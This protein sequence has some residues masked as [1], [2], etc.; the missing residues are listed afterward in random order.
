MKRG[1]LAQLHS[2][3]VRPGVTRRVFSGENATLAF[4]TLE[5]GH[6]AVPHAHPH[7]QI[8]YVLGGTMRFFVGDEEVTVGPG[9]MLVV[10]PGV[11]H[12]AE[13]VGDEP[14]LDLSIF[15]PRRDE[16]AAEERPATAEGSV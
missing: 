13:S 9:D 3:P 7:E 6:A 4:T 5:P 15:S 10:P 11:E 1:T 12:Y 14:V 8:V 16:Y 2:T